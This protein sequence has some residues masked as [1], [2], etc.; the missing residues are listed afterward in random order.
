M[1][2]KNLKAVAVVG[3]GKKVEVADADAL[4][5]WRKTVMESYGE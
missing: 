4:A 1:G 3:A 2:S 5:E